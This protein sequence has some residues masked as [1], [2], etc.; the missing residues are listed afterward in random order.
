MKK[1]FSIFLALSMVVSLSACNTSESVESNEEKD[2]AD[3]SVAEPVVV[4]FATN[5]S[6]LEVMCQAF[7]EFKDY[8]E[9][10]SSGT[11]KVDIYYNSTL[12]TDTDMIMAMSAGNCEM[13]VAG[14]D[15]AGVYVPSINCLSMGYLF[16]TP[17]HLM[18]VLNGEIGE[19][20]SELLV[21]AVGVRYA[22]GY[23]NGSRTVN[24]RMDKEIT[25][26]A[27]LNGIQL[28]MPSS[29]AYVNLG[30]AMGASPV[31]M[32][33]GEVYTAL[34][35]GTVD[36]QDNPLPTILT[37]KYYEVTKSITLT[38][39]IAGDNSVFVAEDFYQSLSDEQK[40]IIDEGIDLLCKSATDIVVE[41][42]ASAVEELEGYGL[43]IYEPD[44]TQMREEVIAWYYD[45]PEVMA[46]WD[47]DILD[48]I[49]AL[50]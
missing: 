41:Q 16:T 2:V 38:G 27:D 7:E 14:S 12:Y 20:F 8:V 25:C 32:A 13:G 43:V 45:H 48:Q 30:K 47:M 22:G 19:H 3:E 29:E 26:T 36:G 33:L 4:R 35:N 23:Y 44:M 6:E 9:E 10:A 5:K 1:L 46:E 31:A 37:E 50:A 18:E 17:E 42:E 34:Q 24:L 39:H 15:K 49:M 28:R 21:D 40:R 11:I